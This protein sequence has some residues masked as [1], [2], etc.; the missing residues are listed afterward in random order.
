[1]STTQINR[2]ARLLGYFRTFWDCRSTSR[3][4]ASDGGAQYWHSGT[5]SQRMATSVRAL[6]PLPPWQS[7]G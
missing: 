6:S 1:L 7:S 3:E 2:T 4:I 5:G